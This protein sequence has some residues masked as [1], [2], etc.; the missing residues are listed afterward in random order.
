MPS[1]KKPVAKDCS[2][3]DSTYMTFGNT[4]SAGMESRAVGAR[5]ELTDC[6]L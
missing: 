6:V 2:L 3:Y 5:D 1:S 4:V